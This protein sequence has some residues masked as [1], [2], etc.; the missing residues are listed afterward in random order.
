M[1]GGDPVDLDEMLKLASSDLER[2]ES[3]FRAAQERVQAAQRHMDELRAM[4][5]GALRLVERYGQNASTI[6]ITDIGA[7]YDTLTV[8]RDKADAGSEG[9]QTDRVMDVLGDGRSA[10]TKVVYE[11]VN[12]TGPPLSYDQVRSALGYLKRKKKILRVGPATWRL[13]Q[14]P[15]VTDSTPTAG[16]AGVGPAGENGSSQGDVL[17]GADLNSQPARQTSF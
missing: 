7:G 10:H 11:K 6:Q 16:T 8:K 12:A 15:A 2:A 4:R 3:D 9:M 17:T 1:E 14:A 13:P 5:D